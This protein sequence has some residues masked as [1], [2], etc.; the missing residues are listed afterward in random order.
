M[1]QG[2]QVIGNLCYDNDKEDFYPE[3]D[4]GPYLVANN[5]FLSETA[6]WDMSEGGAYAHNLIAGKI[7]LNPQGRKT[8][9]FKPHSTILAGVADNPTGDDRFYNNI[10]VQN[11]SNSSTYR[12]PVEWGGFTG[13]GLQI[14]E[15]S[16]G[17]VQADGNIYLNGA[18][19]YAG[20]KN[21]IQRKDLDPAIQLIEEAGQVFLTMTLEDFQGNYKNQLITAALLGKV[22][23]PGCEYENP[24][25]TPVKIDTDYFG[26]KRNEAGP[27]AGPFEHTG[28]GKIKMAVW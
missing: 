12:I 19:H 16:P 23:I 10:F 24:D 13:T 8:P 28:S 11:D 17:P 5:I 6:M 22:I 15:H 18:L 2:T 27:T 21:Y 3:V 1:A 20:E 14:Y 4:H 9:Y 7:Y 26:H 25:G